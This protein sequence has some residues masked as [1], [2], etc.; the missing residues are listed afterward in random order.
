MKVI[1]IG[2]PLDGKIKRFHARWLT[3]P[4]R[5]I[6]FPVRPKLTISDPPLREC[7]PPAIAIYAVGTMPD[8]LLFSGMA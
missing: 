6:R 5:L 4:G 1:C 8:Q 7:K 2:G 3:Q